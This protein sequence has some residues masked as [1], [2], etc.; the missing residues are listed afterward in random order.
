MKLYWV[1]N[2]LI[3]VNE[4]KKQTHVNNN[5]MEV[6]KIA[7]ILFSEFAKPIAHC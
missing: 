3:F 7:V 1:V 5:K 4:I 6:M 2:N